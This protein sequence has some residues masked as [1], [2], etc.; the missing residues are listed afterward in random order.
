V[1]DW[2]AKDTILQAFGDM[3]SHVGCLFLPIFLCL[4]VPPFG[5]LHLLSSFQLLGSLCQQNGCTS[6]L[7]CPIT[8]MAD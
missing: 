5:A 7:S 2:H 4:E 6:C 1:P 3:V 8:S